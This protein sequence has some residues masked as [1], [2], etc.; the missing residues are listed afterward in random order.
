LAFLNSTHCSHH[1]TQPR[2]PASP[3]S[4][5]CYHRW[6]CVAYPANL[7]PLSPLCLHTCYLSRSMDMCGQRRHIPYLWVRQNASEKHGVESQRGN[8]AHASLCGRMAW[9]LAGH[10]FFPAQNKEDEFSDCVL[11]NSFVMARCLVQS[12]GMRT[13]AWLRDMIDCLRARKLEDIDSS[14]QENSIG[15]R[16]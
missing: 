14:T 13:T 3:P 1:V 7:H 12:M 4:H 8:I 9:F 2:S 15:Y 11:G 5:L 6:F 16:T 10:A